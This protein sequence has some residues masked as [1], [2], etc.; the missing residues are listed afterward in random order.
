M[1]HLYPREEKSNLAMKR[2]TVPPLSARIEMVVSHIGFAYI[3]VRN[4]FGLQN[5]LLSF[6]P[7][8]VML[9]YFNDVLN[10]FLNF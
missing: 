2:L 5:W 10:L 6:A 4:R 1:N 8:V 7:C 3:D 9:F